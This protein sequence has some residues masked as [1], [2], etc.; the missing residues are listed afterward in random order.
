MFVIHTFEPDYMIEKTKRVHD[1]YGYRYFKLKPHGDFEKDNYVI[2]KIKEE[3]A[4][5]SHI[6][7]DPNFGLD[8]EIDEV[9]DYLNKLH[10]VGLELCEDPFDKSW[11]DF[12]YVKER[13]PVKIMADCKARTISDVVDIAAADAAEVV[14]IHANWAG[15][16]KPALNKAM[17]GA[18]YGIQ[19]MVG[20]TFY[21]G[22]GVAAYK[23]L[24]A[25]LPG[26]MPCE[27]ESA[28][29]C[30]TEFVVKKEFDVVDGCS[31]IPDSPGLGV[32][33]IPEK[34]EALV[35]EKVVIE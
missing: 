16:F 14:N 1:Q 34:L 31:L 30:T 9:V 15:G 29:E 23:I 11:E 2:T 28:A 17:V 7:I 32:E 33:V 24:S 5:E 18:N 20:S 27:Q 35:S 26:D 3:I 21:T 6:Y 13:T 12:H 22:V 8:M 19:T 25:A 10:K 4:G